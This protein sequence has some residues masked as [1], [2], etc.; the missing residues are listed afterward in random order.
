MSRGPVLTVTITGDA[1]GVSKAT[2]QAEKSF[3]SMGK[4]VS[5][6]A[7]GAGA[8]LTSFG[9]AA[10]PQLLGVGKELLDL[11][12]KSAIF[13]AKAD[14]VFGTSATDVRTWA[15]S[16]NES[17]GVSDE[18]LIGMAGSMGDLLKPMGFTSQEAADMSMKM[19]DLSG[20]LSA[21]SGGQYDAAAVSEIM[22]KAMLG[23]TDGLKALGISISAADVQQRLLEKGQQDLTGAALA[24]AE[25][26]ATQEL[27][28]EKSTDAQ[29]AWTDGTMDATKQA[30]EMSAVVADAKEEVGKFIA[31]G[32]AVAV[33]W[34]TGSF[35]PAVRNLVDEFKQRWPQIREAVQPVLDWFARTSQTV[36]EIAQ[37]AWEIF[38]ETITN[39][40]K[41]TFEM[42]KGYLEGAVEYF[43]GVF[44]VFS[45]IFRGEWGNAWDG[46]KQVVRGAMKMIR[47][48]VVG[49]F[50]MLR[51]VVRFGMEMIGKLIGKGWDL[52]KRL[53]RN[54]VNA[55]VEF[56]RSIPGRIADTIARL[57]G[58]FKEG[59]RIAKEF[60]RQ[61]IADVVEFVR[62]IPGR[63]AKT[64]AGLWTDLKVG[65]AVAGIFIKDRFNDVIDFV[66]GLPARVASAA[67]GLWDGIKDAFRAA[68]NWII[69]KWNALSFNLPSISVFGAEIGGQSFGTPDIPL[70]AKGGIVKARPGGILARIGEG[71][72]DEAVIPLKPGMDGTGTGGGTINNYWPA[73]VNP[74][75]VAAAQRRYVRINGPGSVAA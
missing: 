50:K 39:R 64:I 35:I 2:S 66:T 9:I 53:V 16:V 48:L 52:V 55:Y 28:L 72:Y 38:G 47:A 71:R 46:V 58:G 6:F 62:S 11:G 10:V 7:I 12:R 75:T 4:K 74:A 59:L 15:D 17:M 57:W 56:V 44:K 21:W 51:E 69:G 23:E 30:N 3:S 36:V 60:A 24:Q 37:K 61:R 29:K 73:A 13:Q 14:T 20:A 63:I 26:I 1:K 68:L 40:V 70:L 41:I 49:L 54:A 34:I 18:A 65:I 19:I 42:V 27:I 67:S 32:V 8:A 43:S 22:T 25:A 45:S 31:K 33:K 5:G